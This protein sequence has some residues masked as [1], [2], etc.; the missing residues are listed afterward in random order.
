MQKREI[1][2]GIIG[3]GLMGRE[4]ASAVSR[5]CHLLDMD[6]QPRIVAICDVNPQATAWFEQAIPGLR[7]VTSEYRELLAD[8]EIDAVYCA[9]PH[10]LHA[11]TY[12]DIILSGRHMLGEKPFGIDLAA[13]IAIL[14]AI[15]QRPD[16]LVRCS[17]EFPFFPG[18]YRL[19][20]WVREGRFGQ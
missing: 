5:W 9:L 15:E 3:C 12:R 14:E 17:S 20:Q 11:Q 16:V 1:N 10:N 7:L 13:N 19:A 8:Q 2:F 4:F 18:A 6:V